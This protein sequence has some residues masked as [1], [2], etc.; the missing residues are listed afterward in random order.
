MPIVSNL[1]R[2]TGGS[3]DF[4]VSIQIASP[5]ARYSELIGYCFRPILSRCKLGI[6]TKAYQPWS[7][8]TVITL[9]RSDGS[10]AAP[11][12]AWPR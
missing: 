6:K 12:P 9:V 5:D 4:A 10:I 11:H 7:R 1:L 3:S 8:G 2:Y